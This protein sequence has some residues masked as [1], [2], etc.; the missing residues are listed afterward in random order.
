MIFWLLQ[1][2]EI[3]TAVNALFPSR[4]PYFI[5]QLHAKSVLIQNMCVCLSCRVDPVGPQEEA[6]ARME[7]R[8]TTVGLCMLV[9]KFKSD[10]LSNIN[11]SLNILVKE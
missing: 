1:V 2:S 6:K 5:S 3:R 11:N 8:P 10:K 7:L 9:V 4:E